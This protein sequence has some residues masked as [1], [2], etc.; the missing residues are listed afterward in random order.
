MGIVKRW[1]LDFQVCA[2]V[3]ALSRGLV[4]IVSCG[5][6]YANTVVGSV[7]RRL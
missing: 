6:E 2:E 4:G 3:I 1:C 5:F 7:E